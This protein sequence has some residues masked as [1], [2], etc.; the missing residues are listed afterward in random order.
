M[1]HRESSGEQQQQQQ[2]PE[3]RAGQLRPV[4][5]DQEF[6]PLDTGE[7]RAVRAAAQASAAEAAAPVEEAAP[8]LTS[9]RP[10][11]AL[12]ASHWRK[13]SKGAHGLRAVRSD[14][15]HSSPSSNKQQQQLQP[16]HHHQQQQQQLKYGSSQGAAGDHGNGTVLSQSSHTIELN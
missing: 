13:S 1:A 5:A 14:T 15:K 11:R 10:A 9:D 4:R 6:P 8:A 3:L 16:Q 12:L 7:R 2:Q